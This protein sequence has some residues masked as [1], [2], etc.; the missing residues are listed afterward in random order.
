MSLARIAIR[1]AAVEAIKGR[2][3][4]GAN[5]LDSEIGVLDLDSSGRVTSPEK[6]AFVAVYTD[7]AKAAVGDNDLRS[8]LLNGT[9]DLL[10]ECGMSA[11]MLQ[12]TDP[13]TGETVMA[14][15]VPDTDANFEF[16]LDLLVRQLIEALTD[17]GN[18]WGQV[19]LGL[20]YRLRSVERMRVGNITDG[21][22]LA[23]QQLKVSADLVDDPEPATAL[24]PDSAFGR[25]IT[26][27]Q[28]SEDESLRK[29]GAFMA[30]AITGTREA[31]ENLQQAHG[32]TAAE[33][34]ALGLG[35]LPA[36]ADRSTPAWDS[37]TLERAGL[38]PAVEV[39]P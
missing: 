13:D 28:A 38:S 8:M 9:T 27:A 15:G 35:P 16:Q 4:V 17:P 5:V 3:L 14:I 1:A 2:T 32:M 37:A 18:V 11:A 20:A 21:T 22:R 26:L 39:S 23:A 19:F 7:A 30:A 34:R 33:L 25:F 12:N 29:K 24:D 6:E 31:W 36:D 10:F